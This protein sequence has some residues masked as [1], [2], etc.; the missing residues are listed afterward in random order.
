MGG[1]MWVGAALAT[2]AAA[3]LTAAAFD[4]AA[5]GKAGDESFEAV[6]PEAKP[7]DVGMSAE[8]L[9]RIHEAVQP[10]TDDSRLPGVVTLVARRGRLVHFEAQGRADV[11]SGKAMRKDARSA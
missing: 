8:R 4:Q 2:V 7:E 5:G 6:L 11:E 9:C 1:R 3:A 10:Y